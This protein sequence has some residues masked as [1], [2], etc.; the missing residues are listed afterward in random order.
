MKVN[1]P[2]E[3]LDGGVEEDAAAELDGACLKLL[4]REGVLPLPPDGGA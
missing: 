1:R 4:E 2:R 3:E